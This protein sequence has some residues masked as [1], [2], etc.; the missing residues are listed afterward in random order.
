MIRS[1]IPE[2]FL[3]ISLYGM[4]SNLRQTLHYRTGKDKLFGL[5]IPSQYNGLA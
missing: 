5:Y 4:L 2:E 3:K 1:F